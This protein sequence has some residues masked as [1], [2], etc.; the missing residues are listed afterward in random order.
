MFKK[1]PTLAQKAREVAPVR[2]TNRI[3]CVLWHITYQ[4]FIKYVK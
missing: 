2:H 4:I 1:N 3:F